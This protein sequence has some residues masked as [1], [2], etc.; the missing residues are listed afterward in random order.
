[1]KV[2]NMRSA[3]GSMVANQFIIRHRE[4]IY[5]QSYKS[6][7]ARYNRISY[8]LLITNLWDYSRTTLKYFSRFINEYTFYSYDYKAAF[9]VLIMDDNEDIHIVKSIELMED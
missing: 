5:F 8:Q 7:I 1:M 4:Y 6:V 2:E 9:E 3:R